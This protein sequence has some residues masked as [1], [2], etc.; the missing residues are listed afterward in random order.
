[1]SSPPGTQSSAGPCPDDGSS[2][3]AAFTIAV[4][5]ANEFPLGPLSDSDRDI[6]NELSENSVA[7]SYAGITLSAADGDGSAIVTYALL[8][9]SDELFAVDRDSGRVTLRGALDYERSI[10][11]T[12][13]AQAMS[14]DGSDPS[15]A[16]FVINVLNVNEFAVGSLSDSDGADNEISEAADTGSYIGIT[17]SATDKDRGAV[18]TYALADSSGGLFAVVGA[19]GRVILRAQIDYERST[20]HTIIG[21][22]MSDDGSISTAAF[23][24]A[25]TDAS[26]FPVGPLSD[27]D[28]ADNALSEDAMTGSYA[29][30]TLNAT[31]GDRSAVVTYA[32]ADSNGGIFAVDGD[33][34]RVTLQGSLD[35]ERSTRHTIIGQAMSSDG[36]DPTTRAFTV[37]VIDVNEFPVGPV[38]DTDAADNEISEGASAGSGAGITL[39]ATDRDGSAI[40]AYALVDSSDE[41]FI[42]DTNTGLV[43]LRG[44][45][46]YERST[47][48][49]VI[50]RAMSDDGSSSTA[51]F[52]VAVADANE[53]P[54]GPL[55]DSDQ[56]A[57]NALPENAT[58]GSYAG[59]TLNAADGDR[60]AVVAYA[61][62]DSNG[63]IFAVDGAS[64]RVTLRGELDYEQSTR[65]T[66]IAQAMSSDDSDPTTRAFTVNV[67]DVNEFAVGSLSDSDPAD[68]ALPEGRERRLLRRHH[69][70][71]HRRG[72]Q[73][74]GRLRA[75]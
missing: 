65:H 72:R 27:A 54:V 58:T 47:R 15:T 64:G 7:N 29:G 53:F 66:I 13:I 10:R 38:T 60:S 30:I 68:N 22:A 11:H 46:D 71:R 6:D 3:T 62:S 1:M 52:T 20:R 37:A 36:S 67:I 9:S 73:R 70:Q 59:I 34:G 24:I 12:I 48:H 26:E 2:S 42:A 14:S 56:S 33:S 8:D 28:A 18:V 32:L 35:F 21:R 23:T 75:P 45:L 51:A 4:T 43:A 44:E 5:D 25:V 63:G 50:G 41:L 69:P 61:L 39:S 74:H 57:D 19:S 40:V 49:T 17:L 55:S 16:A 31:D